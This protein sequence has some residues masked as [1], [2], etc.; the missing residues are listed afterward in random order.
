MSK[1]PA[2]C[3]GKFRAVRLRRLEYQVEV[4]CHA[5]EQIEPDIELLHPFGQAI[6]EAL[7]VRVV[8]EQQRLLSTPVA[9]H[10]AGDVVDRSRELNS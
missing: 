1:I 6:K 2:Y 9:Y 3:V 8:L 4:I 7:V 10:S 5:D